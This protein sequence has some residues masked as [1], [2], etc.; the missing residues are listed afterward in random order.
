[1]MENVRAAQQFVGQAV[2]HCGPFYL[3]GSGVPAIAAPG[4]YE[5]DEMRSGD[6]NGTRE[7]ETTRSMTQIDKAMSSSQARARFNSASRHHS[8]RTLSLCL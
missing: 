2:H 7:T 1:M 3:W 5:G 8:S 4:H 6:K